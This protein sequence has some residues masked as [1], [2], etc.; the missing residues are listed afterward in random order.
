MPK[1]FLSPSTQ[2]WNSYVTQG[3]EEL[4]M[5]L[6]ADRMEPYL[7][8]SGIKYA[9]NNP[10]KNVTGA[11]SDSNSEYYDV[12]LAL[13]SN[14]SPENLAGKL[15]GVDIYY[16]PYNELSES[17]ANIIANNMKSIYPLPDKSRALPTTSLGEVTR[18]NAVAVLCELGYH[19]NIYDERWIRENVNA[20]AKNLVQSLCDYFGIPFIEAG[21]IRRGTVI[22]DGSNLNLRAFPSVTGKIIGVIPNGA[23][24][25]VY[26]QY[27]NWYVVG[28]NG[29]I[30]YAS[31]DFIVI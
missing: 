23:V 1:V 10:S 9:R 15:R 31:S 19:D 27:N 18:T 12:H 17:L 14:A 2:E 8:S 3:N 16:Y 22:T 5:N 7:R 26:G 25:T 20:I 13:H 24:V 28:Y 11:I 21:V 4:Y 29:L 6:I 30:G